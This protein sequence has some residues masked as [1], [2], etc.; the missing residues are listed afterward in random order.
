MPR[1]ARV[2][3]GAVG[4]VEAS[5]HLLRDQHET[6]L[7]HGR[8]QA[9][10]DPAQT[11]GLIARNPGCSSQRV[12]FHPN[13]ARDT[14]CSDEAEAPDLENLV[15]LCDYHHDRIDTGGWHVTMRAGVP[16]SYR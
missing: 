5:L 4:A 14:T 8:T 6:V 1:W 9:Q 3:S 16:G 13:I 2:C 11:I 12:T 7:E 10:R 15:L